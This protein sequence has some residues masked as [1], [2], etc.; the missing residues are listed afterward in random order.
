MT[1]EFAFPLAPMARAHCDAIAQEMIDAFGI[2][3]DEAVGR[4]NRHW[5]CA[6]FVQPDDVDT[7]TVDLPD[8]WAR[9]IYYG[10][11]A[12]WWVTGEDGLDPVPYP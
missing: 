3:H 6:E 11:D 12:K 9:R 1:F 10:P 4:I 7:L 8:Y 2:S 5:C